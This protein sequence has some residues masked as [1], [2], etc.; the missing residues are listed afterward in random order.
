MLEVVKP[1]AKRRIQIGND[2]GQA[3]PTRAP[4]LLPYPLAQRQQTFPP[5]PTPAQLEAITEKL[6]T[7]PRLPTISHVG[8]VGIK[9]KPVLFDPHS[10]FVE[11]GLGLFRRAA[12]HHE[13]IGVAHHAA[14]LPSH[15]SVQGM[16]IDIGQKRADH[17]SLR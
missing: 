7:L 1:T 10:H 16:K 8:L 5:D 13:V 14:T 6:K 12:K 9:P 2:T 3:V 15:M 11:R 17:R 4:S